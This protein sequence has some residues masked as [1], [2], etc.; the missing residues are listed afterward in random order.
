M[1]MNAGSNFSGANLSGTNLKTSLRTSKRRHKHGASARVVSHQ[2][3][4]PLH[5]L[6]HGRRH[7]VHKAIERHVESAM[8]DAAFRSAVQPELDLLSE[9]YSSE[10]IESTGV[11]G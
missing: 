10:Q 8:L 5:R 4:E 11:F 3:D 6:P 9:Q 2:V 7:R 1:N